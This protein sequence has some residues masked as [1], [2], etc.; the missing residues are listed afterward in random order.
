ME[1][2]YE[3]MDG[4]KTRG[5]G[6]GNGGPA[7]R[8]QGQEEEMPAATGMA[9]SKGVQHHSSDPG[10]RAWDHCWRLP[11]GTQRSVWGWGGVTE[12]HF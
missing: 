1:L 5:Q 2:A 11:S 7:A 9:R 12:V 3:I 8:S 6:S 10:L 4:L